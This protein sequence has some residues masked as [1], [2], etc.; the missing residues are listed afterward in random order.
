MTKLLTDALLEEAAQL[1]ANLQDDI[2]SASTRL[3]HVRLTA[4]ENEAALLAQR[5]KDINTNDVDA[6]AAN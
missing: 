1:A 6:E 4:R 3:E 2:K 5:L